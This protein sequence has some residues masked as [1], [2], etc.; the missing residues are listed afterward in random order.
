MKKQKLLTLTDLCNFYENHKNNITYSS[1]EHN[2]ESVVVQVDGTMTFSSDDYDPELGMLKVHVRSSHIGDNA[3]RSNIEEDVMEQGKTSIYNRPLLGYIHKLK[4]GSY[5]FAG[6]EMFINDDGEIEYEEIPVGCIPE[7]CSAE[8]VYDEDEDKTYLEFDAYVYE[9]YTRAANILRDK[10]ECKVSVELCLL[11]YSYAPKD[12]KLIITKFYFSGVTILGVTRDGNETP[13]QEGMKGSKVTLKDFKSNNSLFSSFD[14]DTNAKIIEMLEKINCTLTNINMNSDQGFDNNRKEEKNTLKLEELL[15]KYEKNI[16]DITFDYSTMTDDEIELKMKELF[17]NGDG[18]ENNN[19]E[20]KTV[21]EDI[22]ENYIK[23]Y[24]LSHEDIRNALH[25]LL[26]PYEKADNEYYWIENVFD[27]YFIY[28]A[29][30]GKIWQQKYTK[31][32]S[33]AISF[34]GDRCELFKEYLTADELNTLKEM[35]TNYASIKSELKAYK[36]KDLTAQKEA[37]FADESYAEYLDT[38]SFK[39][40][41]SN[42]EKYSVDELKTQCELAFAKE[43]RKNKAA[44]SAEPQKEKKKSDVIPF[45]VVNH[46]SNFLDGLLDKKDK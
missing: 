7:S 6:H 23:T 19:P 3:N 13:I 34:E 16:E 5:H 43:I 2:G 15:A 12:R 25:V 10:K 18:V 31:D 45:M 14:E 30:R 32:D 22:K 17:D 26:E 33:D 36:E 38:E 44:F 40:L 37:V 8:L 4:D 11:D 35:R 9:E 42:I 27:N 28:S 41:K 1:K 29:Y 20:L 46:E 39:D 24:N 21:V